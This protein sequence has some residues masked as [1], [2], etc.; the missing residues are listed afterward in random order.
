MQPAQTCTHPDLGNQKKPFSLSKMAPMRDHIVLAPFPKMDIYSQAKR[1]ISLIEDPLWKRICAEVF[2]MMGHDSVLKIEKATLGSFSPED[3]TI[4]LCCQ[5]EDVARFIHEYS[6]VI[7]GI[8]KK[9]F[10]CINSL[11]IKIK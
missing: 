5:T 9:Y 1:C 11:S 7:I 3:K 6:F 8:L 2:T 4:E 10:P